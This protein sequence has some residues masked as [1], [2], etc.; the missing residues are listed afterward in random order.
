MINKKGKISLQVFEVV[1]VIILFIDEDL[2]IY[3]LSHQYQWPPFLQLKIWNWFQQNFERNLKYFKRSGTH[4]DQNFQRSNTKSPI[5]YTVYTEWNTFFQNIFCT[6]R[7]LVLYIHWK[8]VPYVPSSYIFTCTLVGAGTYASFIFECSLVP[9][10]GGR[11]LI[12]EVGHILRIHTATS[13]W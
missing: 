4:F 9:R 12:K 5:F 10:R 7:P 13:F 6:E 8:R 1:L 11:V 2:Y 3:E